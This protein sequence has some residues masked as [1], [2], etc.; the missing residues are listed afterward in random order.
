[1]PRI[2]YALIG[3]MLVVQGYLEHQYLGMALGTYFTAMG[4][5]NFGCAASHCHKGNCYAQEQWVKEKSKIENVEL[6][7]IKSK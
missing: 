4:I 2:L 3:I 7:E 1:M 6:D 5:F